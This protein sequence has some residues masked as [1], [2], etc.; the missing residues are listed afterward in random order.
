M[1]FVYFFDELRL[2]IGESELVLYV[3]FVAEGAWLVEFLV[4]FSRT[5]LF[6][7]G[8]ADAVE[9]W[10]FE[11]LFGR[12]TEHGVELKETFQEFQELRISLGEQLFQLILLLVIRLIEHFEKH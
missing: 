5:T 6:V 11:S 8:N 12:Q 1:G 7:K 9:N 3:A 2:E 10:V 4:Y